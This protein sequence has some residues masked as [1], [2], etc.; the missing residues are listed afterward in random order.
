MARVF[1]CLFIL[2]FGAVFGA[3]AR[4]NTLNAASCN[5]SDVQGA[6]N[7]ASEGDTVLI[8]AGTCT[9]TSGVTISGKGI[10]LQGAGSGRIVA[11]SSTTL[12]I[13]T[14]TLAL[15]ISS[16][17][18]DGTYPLGP[19]SGQTLTVYELGTESNFMTGSVESFNSASGA[20]VMSVTNAGGSCRSN[21]LSN[22][23]RWLVSTQSSTVIINN[24]S[25]TT[26]L[27][28]ITEDTGFDTSVSGIKVAIGTGGAHVINWNY[29]SGGRPLLLHDCWIQNGTG[30]N[31]SGN[32][33]LINVNTLRGVIWNCSFDSSPP[34]MAST[35]NV[36]GAISEQDDTN[37]TGNSWTSSSQFGAKDT[38]G[39]GNLYVETNDFHAFIF[40]TNTDNN[41]R[42]VARYNLYDNS[43][44]F[45]THGADTSFYGQRYFEFYNNVGNF[46][47]Y[48]D[49]TTFNIGRWFYIRGGTF[50]IHDNTIPNLVSTD[51]GTKQNL[52]MTVMNL[53][54]VGGP[55][56]CWGANTSGGAHYHAPRQV[57]Y[58]YVTGAG[59]S[60]NSG[61]ITHDAYTYVG[62]S[63]PA[64]IWNNTSVPLANV[65]VEDYG[66]TA[67]DSCEAVNGGSTDTSANY[68]V[69]NRD[70]FNGST[71]K[72]GYTPYTYPHPLSLGKNLSAGPAAP[73]NLSATVSQ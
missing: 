57:G 3:A 36:N 13:G 4:A 48:N 61:G 39:A 17:R 52:T 5:A 29:Q 16:S 53:Q 2:L 56:G 33:S 30:T 32:A 18:V 73:S 40:A 6:I 8:P 12:A 59:Q 20:L 10:I 41:G 25:T 69:L 11:T 14:G 50:V 70:Y 60:P 42:Q 65:D 51:Y 54:R 37:A 64:Y 49:G 21:S 66:N 44:M 1:K 58:G 28:N 55:D 45:G 71:A 24:N 72:P 35:G 27:F 43:G 47:G 15:T 23:K 46:N 67:S 38:T 19:T 7:S 63:E 34:S 22:C 31:P 62:D 9:W 26:P 68:V